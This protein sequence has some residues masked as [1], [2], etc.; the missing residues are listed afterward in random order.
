MYQHHRGE[1]SL[2]TRSKLALARG[3]SARD[4]FTAQQ[5]RTWAMDVFEDIFTKQKIDVIMSPVTA[6]TAP[7]IKDVPSTDIASVAKLMRYA[8]VYNMIG[9]P[10][11][12]VPVG[13]DEH[14]LPI[15]LQ[16]AAVHWHEHKLLRLANVAEQALV[17]RAPRVFFD[18]LGD[19]LKP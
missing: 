16:L 2:D 8:S 6:S 7:R 12:S 9:A 19:A 3:M 4:Y 13:Y 11:V 14:N 10:A 18:I 15:G 1:F 17:R 5:V